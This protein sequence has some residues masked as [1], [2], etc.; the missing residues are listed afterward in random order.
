MCLT[1][2]LSSRVP[3][4][5]SV[6]DV[7]TIQDARLSLDMHALSQSF[8][9]HE[10]LITHITS[11]LRN[12]K[13][14]YINITFDDKRIAYY[15]KEHFLEHMHYIK[16]YYDQFTTKSYAVRNG[17]YDYTMPNDILHK[18]HTFTKPEL[19]FWD[20]LA[21]VIYAIPLVFPSPAEQLLAKL[22]IINTRHKEVAQS[23]LRFA[24]V[25]FAALAIIL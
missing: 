22:H 19:I 7:I 14:K 6:G 25:S 13:L 17:L 5:V 20:E 15:S 21:H 9:R 2:P 18:N 3:S 16:Q 23:V 24:P 1:M 11:F 12:K 4:T 10:L 8:P